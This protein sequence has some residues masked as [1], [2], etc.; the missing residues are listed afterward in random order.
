MDAEI[1]LVGLAP[2][3][4]PS[5]IGILTACMGVVPTLKGMRGAPSAASAGFATLAATCQGAALATK[6]DGTNRIFAGTG[7]K[8]YEAASS[9]W[10][11]VS[12][13]AVY[14]TGSTNRWRFAQQDNV[15]FAAN[16]ADTVQAS[17]STGAFSCIAGAPVAA[18]VETVGKFV[19]AA[20]TITATNYIQWSALNDY[21]SWAASS[22]TQAGND[23]LKASPGPI[24]AARKFG[25]QIIVYKQASMYVGTYQNGGPTIWSFSQIPG[26]AGALSQESVV[27]I[28]TPDNPKHIFMGAD[29][30][31]LYNGANP[32][33]IGTNRVKQ[34]VFNSLVQS[35]YYACQ[36]AHDKRNS[37][38][39]FYYPTVDAATPNACV[40]YNYRTDRWGADDRVVEATLDYVAPSVTYSGAGSALSTYGTSSLNLGYGIAFAGSTQTL[41]GVFTSSHL[42]TT[43][44]GPAASS[45]FTTGD[46]GDD[47]QFS[48]LLRV[49]PRFIT[50]PTSAT[51]TNYY[52]NRSGDALTTG[53]TTALDT[54]KFDVI[55]DA[56]WHRFML[57]FTGDWEM[58]RVKM[59]V[60]ESGLE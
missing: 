40:V 16:G 24:T 32:I 10:S 56:R 60:E 48:T 37:L 35:R 51:L 9:T 6:L 49:V 53:L 23:T 50:A 30:F 4:D 57:S 17:V 21:T 33:P 31:Y 38:V 8:L 42:L 44:T 2:D 1:P 19:F 26:N 55:V 15:S 13:S 45:S 47:N 29:D 39:Y 14:N 59:T 20:N 52:K 18:I 27:N 43:L 5:L 7:T 22:A 34:Y 28:G 12:R 58:S 36:A 11:D 25:S 3:A 41:P 46:I 54:G